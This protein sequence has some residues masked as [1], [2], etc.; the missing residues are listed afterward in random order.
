MPCD[1]SGR[2]FQG[3]LMVA[4]KVA[5]LAASSPC[6]RTDYIHSAIGFYRRCRPSSQWK[7]NTIATWTNA[8]QTIIGPWSRVEAL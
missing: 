1:Y 7:S 4:S 2:S 3:R 5:L 6:R 8:N